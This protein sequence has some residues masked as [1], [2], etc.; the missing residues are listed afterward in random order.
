MHPPITIG[1]RRHAL[2]ALST[3]PITLLT[4]ATLLAAGCSSVGPAGLRSGRTAWSRAVADTGAEQTLLS[5]VRGRYG[6]PTAFLAVS[7]ITSNWKLSVQPS[8]NAGFGPSSSY[9]GNLVPFGLSVVAEENP[10]VSYAPISGSRY[11]AQF[12][13]P[14]DPV[15]AGRM[16]FAGLDPM[17]AALT[18]RLL[19]GEINA[20]HEPLLIRPETDSHRH[21]RLDDHFVEIS[22]AFGELVTHGG[23]SLVLLAEKEPAILFRLE[24]RHRPRVDRLFELLSLEKPPAD[25]KVAELRISAV[26]RELRSNEIF[27]RCRSIN[28]LNRLAMASIEVPEPERPFAIELAPAPGFAEVVRIRSG[29]AAPNDASLVVEH[30]GFYY[31]IDDRDIASKQFFQMIETLQT[32]MQQDDE[33]AAPML[34]LP[35]ASG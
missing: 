26:P 2:R 17:T 16:V 19:V 33:S 4:A 8:V 15:V 35:V 34:T 14:I 32:L 9:A 10:T 30:R 21:D 12:L 6:E 5:I 28:E 1:S 11:S 25:A 24:P 29:T 3:L 31:W 23:T 20:I 18:F 22:N 13:A 7:A 27:L